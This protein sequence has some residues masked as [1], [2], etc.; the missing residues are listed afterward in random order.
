VSRCNFCSLKNLERRAQIEGADVHI[1]PSSLQIQ[2]ASTG[3]DVFVVS[4]GEVLD[5]SVDARGN[6]G[7][8]WKVWFASIPN[9]CEC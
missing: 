3:R 7:K 1:L 8:Q 5:T 9:S 4:K 6:H 2:N